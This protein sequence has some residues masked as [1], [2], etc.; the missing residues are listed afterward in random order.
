MMMMQSEIDFL[1]LRVIT[2]MNI[3]AMTLMITILVAVETVETVEIAE[4]VETIETKT[5]EKRGQPQHHLCGGGKSD[6]FCQVASRSERP[7]SRR[8]SAHWWVLTFQYFFPWTI[9]LVP[10]SQILQART[11]LCWP[12]SERQAPTPALPLLSWASSV[13]TRLSKFNVRGWWWWWFCSGF[14]DGVVRKIFGL[15]IAGVPLASLPW[16]TQLCW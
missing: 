11:C 2:F 7:N 16:W 10:P 8:C 9:R 1:P 3:W 6:A 15:N 5:G 13:R 14:A 4:T 12:T